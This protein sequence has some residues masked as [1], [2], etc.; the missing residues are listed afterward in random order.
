MSA[1]KFRK[2]SGNF[3]A[4]GCSHSIN[5][6]NQLVSTR[7]VPHARTLRK[8]REQVKMMVA[9]GFSIHRTRSYLEKW[10]L[11]WTMTT[12]TWSYK[13][14]LTVFI[15][16]CWDYRPAAV[17]EGLLRVSTLLDSRDSSLAAVAA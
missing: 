10:A 9:T 15:Q 17:A 7:T 2:F 6:Q 4:S 1:I 3:L 13:E 11:W 16:S 14:L 5:E 12:A 8:A